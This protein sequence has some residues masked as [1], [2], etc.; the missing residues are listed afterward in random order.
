MIPIFICGLTI[1]MLFISASK[2]PKDKLRFIFGLADQDDS[3][4]AAFARKTPGFDRLSHGISGKLEKI[5]T[6]Y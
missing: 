1:A 6:Y 4:S 3:H 2:A 5:G